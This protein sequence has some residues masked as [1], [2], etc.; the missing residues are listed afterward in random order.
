MNM[1]HTTLEMVD[2]YGTLVLVFLFVGAIVYY[3]NTLFRVFLYSTTLST[4]AGRKYL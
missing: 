2:A 4:K 1:Y 3:R